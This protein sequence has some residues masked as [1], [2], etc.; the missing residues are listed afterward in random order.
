MIF[1]PKSLSTCSFPEN[2]NTLRSSTKRLQNVFQQQPQKVFCQLNGA[3]RFRKKKVLLWQF[4]EIF[5]FFHQKKH[6]KKLSFPNSPRFV[7]IQGMAPCLS[8]S[9]RAADCATHGICP[10]AQ[11]MRPGNPSEGG[12][13]SFGV[14]E[15]KISFF[16]LH[17]ILK[18]GGAKQV[19]QIDDDFL[20]SQPFVGLGCTFSLMPTWTFVC[21]HGCI[22]SVF[23][24]SLPSSYCPG[25]YSLASGLAIL[26]GEVTLVKDSLMSCVMWC[27]LALFN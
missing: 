8:F 23:P 12:R 24:H 4:V 3:S 20:G 14:F 25:G 7:E 17:A 5:H 15:A 9:C 1:L 18:Q 26:E 27:E 10:V 13:E 6:Q 11:V 2:K 21:F 19:G 22:K 16:Y